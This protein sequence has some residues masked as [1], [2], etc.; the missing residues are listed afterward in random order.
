MSLSSNARRAGFVL[1]SGLLVLVA[2]LTGWHAVAGLRWPWDADMF[3]NIANGVT[4]KDGEVLRD[5]H[6]SGV[7]AWYSPLTSALLALGSVVTS[8]PVNRLGT[9]GGAVL[10][11][12]TPLALCWIT[13]R[14]FG[15]R[16]GVLALLAYLFVMG[17]N[18]PSSMIASYSP[19]LLVPI[20]AVGIYILA[21]AAVPDAVNRASTK[22]ALLL[23]IAGGVV[24]LAHP[25]AAIVLAGVVTVQFL[26]A[27]W[28]APAPAL[29]RLTRS[30][31]ISA[32]AALIVSAPFW[33]PIMIRYRGRGSERCPRQIYVARARKRSRLDVLARVL[34]A[35]ANAGDR[36]R[37]S[38][39]DCP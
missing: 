39:V 29:R 12:L 27:C 19:W 1:I 32:F 3:R 22:D 2:F 8:L 17:N 18:Y 33:L 14:W 5:S 9:Q 23:G 10:N 7:P 37:S 6:F 38:G 24:V 15:R 20:Y 25:A 21:L 35:L 11:L 4:F 30:A 16:V 34:M 28:H 31:A 13:A 36:H 26:G